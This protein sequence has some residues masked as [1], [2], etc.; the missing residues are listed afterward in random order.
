MQGDSIRLP[1][2][3]KAQIAFASATL[4]FLLPSAAY[5]QVQTSSHKIRGSS[6]VNFRAEPSINAAVVNCLQPD[7]DVQIFRLPPTGRFIWVNDREGRTWYK[8]SVPGTNAVGWIMPA[9]TD[10]FGNTTTEACTDY[11]SVAQKPGSSS[12]TTTPSISS[13]P[14]AIVTPPRKEPRTSPSPFQPQPSSKPPSP[15]NQPPSTPASPHIIKIPP[16]TKPAEWTGYFAGGFPDAKS[17]CQQ[18]ATSREIPFKEIGVEPL[19]LNNDPT[20][21]VYMA[22]CYKDGNKDNRIGYT[23]VECKPEVVEDISGNQRTQYTAYYKYTGDIDGK[24]VLDK[25]VA[26]TPPPTSSPVSQ[27]P[28]QTRELSPLPTPTPPSGEPQNR[29][30]PTPSPTPTPFPQATNPSNQQPVST[31]SSSDRLASE[32]G[33]TCEEPIKG[34]KPGLSRWWATAGK[35]TQ[36]PVTWTV[37]VLTEGNYKLKIFGMTGN[38]QGTISSWLTQS[39]SVIINS[40]KKSKTIETSF[41]TVDLGCL[42]KGVHHLKID[43]FKIPKEANIKQFKFQLLTGSSFQ[44]LVALFVADH[45]EKHTENRRYSVKIEGQNIKIGGNDLSRDQLISYFSPTLYFESSE[46]YR[47]PFDVEKME[48]RKLRKPGI[49][50]KDSEI[51]EGDSQGFIDL[52]AWETGDYSDSKKAKI[53]AS[54]LEKKNESNGN[55]EL[56]I[57]Y[58]FHYPLSNWKEH[59]GYNNHS[60]DWEGVT[61]FLRK[62]GNDWIPD[63]MAFSQHVK[64]ISSNT[65]WKGG[66]EVKWKDLMIDS[67]RQYKDGV[68]TSS[69]H[70]PM[71][72]VGLGGHASYPYPGSTQWQQINPGSLWRCSP[73]INLGCTEHHSGQISY[74]NMYFESSVEYLP[75]VGSGV[76]NEGGEA[77]EWLLYSGTWGDPDKGDPAKD[78]PRGPVFQDLELTGIISDSAGQGLRWLDPWAWSKDFEKVTRP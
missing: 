47:I 71:V 68:V 40:S 70:K 74:N 26:T 24:C 21:G 51:S 76:K 39:A 55:Q 30:E 49:G 27:T 36:I 32:R 31:P 34:V 35:D 8:A 2:M 64:Y 38:T 42:K 3:N 73:L 41:G 7:T 60:G 23:S 58:F 57:N 59:G 12:T 78:A 37:A 13:S 77:P 10:L 65:P 22:N 75:R 53:Y 14:P 63:R 66:Q 11:G 56:A 44:E 25:T 29:R 69:K 5:P 17:A 15:S 61:L 20:Q 50:K 33:E 52:S 48:W 4:M 6:C 46:R 43:S 62:D 72:W 19:Y 9:C 1:K 28:Q 54:I 18:W 67:S 45:Q 16:Q